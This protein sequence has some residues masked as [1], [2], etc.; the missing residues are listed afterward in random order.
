MGKITFILGGTRSGKSSFAVKLAEES[1]KK[2]AFIATCVPYDD[3]MQ[4]RVMLHKK[5]RSSEWATFEEPKELAILLKNINNQFETVIIDCITLFVT[6]L[7]M[8]N[9]DD[10][11]INDRITQMMLAL[12]DVN[13]DTYIVSNEVGLGIVPDN[14]LAR[15]FRDIAG[16]VN[17]LIASHADNVF[18]MVSGIPMKVK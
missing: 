3:E 14:A 11:V 18:F 4:T 6:N 9:L 7:I 8:D 17:Q 10:N 2:T 16:K 5:E 1:A 13:Y 15:R 12:K